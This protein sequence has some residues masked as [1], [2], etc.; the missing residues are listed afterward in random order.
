MSKKKKKLDK[1]LI[2][3]RLRELEA[4]AKVV[5]G[6]PPRQK[7]MK[8]K[9]YQTASPEIENDQEK[10]TIKE[11]PKKK[12]NESDELILRDVKKVAILCTVIIVI[13]VAL[14]FV[15]LKTNYLLKA[16]DKIFNILHVGQLSS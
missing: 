13:F 10:V 5:K 16:S 1:K 11:A 14:Y 9:T 4:E 7:E 8:V 3:E 15:N 12:F 6:S 2:K